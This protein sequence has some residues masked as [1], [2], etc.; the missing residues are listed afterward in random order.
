MFS[1]DSNTT[2][3]FTFELLNDVDDGEES[4]VVLLK[5][6]LAHMARTKKRSESTE[7]AL[8]D[9]RKQYRERRNEWDAEKEEYENT[10]DTLTKEL[11]QATHENETMRSE[12][13][14]AKSAKSEWIELLDRN[15][16][17]LEK[18]ANENDQLNRFILHMY[19]L[20]LLQLHN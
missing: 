9:L 8:S 10:I 6:T 17:E 7:A 5:E 20:Y 16:I 19:F 4:V 14:K 3:E 13:N 1:T 18:V 12:L 2:K 15:T 11:A